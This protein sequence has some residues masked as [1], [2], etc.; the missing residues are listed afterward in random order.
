MTKIV[1]TDHSKQR[2]DILFCQCC[3]KKLADY[4]NDE[5]PVPSYVELYAGGAIPVPNFGWICSQQCA[6]KYEKETGITFGR[7]IEG[8]I[9]Y[10]NGKLE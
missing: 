9:D 2:K 3:S 4:T 5:I 10:Y 7:T 6:E 1:F 8:K